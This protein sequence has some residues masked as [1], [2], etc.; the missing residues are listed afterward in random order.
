MPRKKKNKIEGIEDKIAQI[1][2][3]IEPTGEGA[4]EPKEE[5]KEEPKKIEEPELKAEVEKLK[6]LPPEQLKEKVVELLSKVSSY[7]LSEEERIKFI[8]QFRFWNGVMFDLLDISNHLKTTVGQA[9]FSL[10]P[11]QALLVYLGGTA[12]L[13]FL[14]RPDLQN[15]IFRKQP[16]KP[17]KSE[18]TSFKPE[19]TLKEAPPK[20]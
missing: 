20:E 7:Q 6:D 19:E 11:W 2:E 10:S 12:G 3:F 9:S 5:L 1:G 15:R 4:E 8:E 17:P 18:E 16:S 14:L 13:V